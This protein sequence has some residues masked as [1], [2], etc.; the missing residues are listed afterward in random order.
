MD[1]SD[2]QLRKNFYYLCISECGDFTSKID[3]LI[4]KIIELENCIN[5]LEYTV[6]LLSLGSIR[7]LK[8]NKDVY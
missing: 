6:N 4:D 7:N 3:L 1:I 2:K 8:D 5:E